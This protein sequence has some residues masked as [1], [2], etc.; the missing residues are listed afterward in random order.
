MV[1]IEG[2]TGKPRASGGSKGCAT[3]KSEKAVSF[4]T[5]IIIIII[6]FNVKVGKNSLS[7]LIQTH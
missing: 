2:L 4:F 1:K 6:T 3:W 7:I 5:I